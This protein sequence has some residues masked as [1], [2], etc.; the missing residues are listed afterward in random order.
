[1]NKIIAFSPADEKNLKYFEMLEKSFHKFHPD[2]ELRRYDNPNMMDKDFW[3]RA[4]PILAKKLFEEGFDTVIKL[5]SD[6]IILGSLDGIWDGEFDVA[7]VLNDP[8]Y[9][10]NTWGIQPYFN[11]GLV[12]M[13]S[14]EFV[15]HWERLCFSKYFPLYQFREQD[16][17]NILASEYMNYK[18][19][20]LDNE[21]V[22][23]EWGKFLWP[24]A[25]L[26]GKEI[27][28][29]YENKNLPLCVYHSG[30]GNTPDKMNYRIRFSED[31]VK[32]I[33]ELIE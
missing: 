27:L 9:S 4:T 12:V 6:Q 31:V 3:Y 24:Q 22:Y 1:M 30:G 23:G 28:I 18:V 15:E 21:K 2:I 14:K 7:C 17:L 29:P 26:K 32:R 8:T 13:K 5:D 11:N 19:K 20:I 33:E 16:L 25:Y 10:I